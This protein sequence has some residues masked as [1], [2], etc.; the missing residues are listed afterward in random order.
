MI[1]PSVDEHA[2]ASVVQ[3][4]T[5]VPV[6][7]MVKNELEAVLK[8]AETLNQRV[9]GQRHALEMIAKRIQTS[10]ARLDNP[11]KPIGV[12]MLC[13][14]SGVGKTETALALAEALYGGEQNVIT[15][16]MSEFQEAHTVST[17]KG[18]PPGYV[19]YG[20][21]G[22]LTEAV[23]RRPYSVVL[24]DEVEKAHSDVHELFFQ[25][26][27][28][29]WMEDG[30]GR[31]IDFKNTIILLTSNVGTELIASMCKD[32]ELMPEPEGIAKG[33][34][35]PL[36]KKFPAALLGRL[37]VIPYYPLSDVMLSNIA[38]LQLGRI[39][40][41]RDRTSQDPVH[42]RRRGAEADR[43]PLR[44]GRERRPD[45]RRDPHEHGAADDQP[46]VSQ[47]D[48]GRRA[49]EPRPRRRRRRRFHVSVRLTGIDMEPPASTERDVTVGEAMKMALVFQQRGQ[50]D[51][52][53]QVYRRVLE[54]APDHPDI[55]HFYGVLLHQLGRSEEA[56]A[57]IERS[58]EL[59]PDRAECYNNLGIILRAVER[60]EDAAAAYARATEL[61]PTHANAYNNLGVL[62]RFTGKPAEAE[63][64][65][66]KAIELKPT[67]AE[68]YHNL[69][70]LLTGQKRHREAILCYFKVLS[71]EPARTDD[72]RLLA[73]AY[74]EIGERDKAIEIFEKWIKDDPESPVANHMLAAVTGRNVPARAS[75]AY[76]ELSFDGFAESFERKLEQLSYRAPSLVAAAIKGS[77]LEAGGVRS[78]CSTPAA[79]PGCAARW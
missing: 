19:G 9:V 75:D 39:A 3:D 2:V 12:F 34:R 53:A 15:I 52:A 62:R 23:R 29:G 74:C 48:D 14:P 22:V 42:L 55:V 76:V 51:D 64:A 56:I 70:V 36:L 38:R 10:R 78:T 45:G 1:L 49:D 50:L 72:R 24:L 35:D 11:N 17:L 5:G 71:L 41:A 30:E 43:E 31:R 73:I 54:V 77:G 18:A 68:A 25:V 69:G 33:L 4:W 60:Y 20:E 26:F 40:Q 21:G 59:E 79:A 57:T 16:N 13:G 37:V 6:G 8:L 66:R 44:R 58:L 61:D 32:P 46:R 63:A 65:Y 28:K 67:Y 27:D 7:R 47:P